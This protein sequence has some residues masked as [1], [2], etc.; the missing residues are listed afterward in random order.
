[1]DP[2]PFTLVVISALSHAIWNFLTKGARDKDSYMLLMNLTSQLTFIPVFFVL[3]KDWQLTI[4]ALP[5]LLVSSAAETVYFLGLSG[6]YEAGDLSVVYPV[7]RSSPLF[8]AILATLFMGEKLTSWGV[9]GISLIIAGVYVLHLRSL[10]GGVLRTLHSLGG[11]ASQLALVAALGTTVYSLAD[12]AA[13]SRIDPLLYAFWLEIFI[14]MFLTPAII[15]RK[16][17]KSVKAEWEKSGFRVTVSGFL[18]RGGY[19]LVLFAMVVSPISYLLALRQVSVVIGAALGVILLREGY[20]APR[21]LGSTII[22]A[23]V[24]VLGTL[25]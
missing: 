13:V 18:M 15:V 3:L 22:F 10:R 20:G 16:G 2:L 4:E 5:F 21:L 9:V 17:L 12:K 24:Y 19:L 14:T 8:V 23:G 1:M 7:A 25:A 11:R 6:A